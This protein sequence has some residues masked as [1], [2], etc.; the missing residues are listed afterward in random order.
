M[1][2]VMTVIIIIFV[3]ASLIYETKLFL[4]DTD[5]T[6]ETKTNEKE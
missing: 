1:Q 6:T 4:G 5:D 3:I 2:V